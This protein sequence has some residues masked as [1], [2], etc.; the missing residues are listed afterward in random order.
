M[1]EFLKALE[2]SEFKSSFVKIKC[3]FI[4]IKS[5]FLKI[6]NGQV[7]FHLNVKLNNEIMIVGFVVPKFCI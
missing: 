1:V 2:E 5:R 7:Y 3:R 6:R 4:E